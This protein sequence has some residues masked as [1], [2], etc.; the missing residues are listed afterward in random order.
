MKTPVKVTAYLAV[1]AVA[2]GAAFGLGALTGSP[3]GTDDRQPKQ[4]QMDMPMPSSSGSGP[5]SLSGLPAAAQQTG[6]QPTVLMTQV[7]DDL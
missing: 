6:Q 3:A 7:R 2:F 1:L 4:E 5:D